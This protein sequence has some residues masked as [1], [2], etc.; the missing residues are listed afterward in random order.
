[1]ST[2]VAGATVALLLMLLNVAFLGSPGVH[3]LGLLP[4]LYVATVEFRLFVTPPA[5]PRT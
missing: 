3:A 4:G 1:M 5:P 2:L